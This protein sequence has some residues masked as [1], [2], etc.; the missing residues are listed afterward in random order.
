MFSSAIQSIT[1]PD[2]VLSEMVEAWTSCLEDEII[3]SLSEVIFHVKDGDKASFYPHTG[4]LKF[5]SFESV[6]RGTYF[7][8]LTMDTNAN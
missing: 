2:S 6:S 4:M 5:G 3:P 8:N 7:A 1:L